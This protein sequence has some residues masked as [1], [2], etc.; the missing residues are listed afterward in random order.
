M[1]YNDIEE[2]MKWINEIQAEIT[3]DDLKNMEA[4]FGGF[5]FQ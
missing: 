5:N 1:N 3:D 2:F 4:E